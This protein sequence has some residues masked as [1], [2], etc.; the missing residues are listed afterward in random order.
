MVEIL[1]IDDRLFARDDLPW[2]REI[3]EVCN[4][5]K[6]Q[7]TFDLIPRIG[8][9][10]QADVVAIAGLGVA[11]ASLVVS[12]LT[13]LKKSPTDLSYDILLKEATA[14]MTMR[15]RSNFKFVDISGFSNL[16]R[17]NGKPC[18]ITVQFSNREQVR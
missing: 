11:V 13:L 6:V 14:F 16:V 8:H 1:Y 4:A 3:V 15:G 2:R 9:L 10:H 12:I 7:V 17:K 18:V 5:E